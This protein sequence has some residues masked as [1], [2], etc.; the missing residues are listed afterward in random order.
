MSTSIGS[1]SNAPAQGFDV[2]NIPARLDAFRQGAST[3][4]SAEEV[5]RLAGSGAR[6]GDAAVVDQFLSDNPQQREQLQNAAFAAGN[7]SLFHQLNQPS[8]LQMAQAVPPAQQAQAPQPPQQTQQQQPTA[9]AN[10]RD[11]EITRADGSV[12][13]RTGGTLAWRN[14]NP[15]NIRA[16]QFAT[17]HGAI[18]TGPGGFAVFPDEATGARAVGSLLQTNAYRDLS[19]NDAVMRYAPPVENNTAAYQRAIQNATGLDG[20]RTIS[21]LN[22][23]ELSS[24]VDAIRQQEGW[25][26]GQ[27]TV[28]PAPQ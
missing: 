7:Y 15:G 2:S 26:A 16:G 25:R 17:N 5:Q 20:T 1:A 13:Q 21:S 24:V 8:L 22:A 19:I 23:Q 12:E 3:P 9:T 4:A 11:T 27:T 6:A 18:G 28:T 14:N 10:G